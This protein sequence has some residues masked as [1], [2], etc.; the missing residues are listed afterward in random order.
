M[1]FVDRAV[2]DPAPVADRAMAGAQTNRPGVSDPDPPGY[3][4]FGLLAVLYP[5]ALPHTCGRIF[6]VV[7]RLGHR[8]LHTPTFSCLGG[9]AIPSPRRS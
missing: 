2:S 3:P 1:D 4:Q 8:R 7:G 6:A 9:R 5:D